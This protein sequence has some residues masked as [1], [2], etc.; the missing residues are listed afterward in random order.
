MQTQTLH[1]QQENT[2]YLFFA[3]FEKENKGLFCFSA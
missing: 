2:K 1:K 3:L